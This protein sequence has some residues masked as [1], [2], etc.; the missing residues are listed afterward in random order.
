MS[1]TIGA[2]SSVVM[3]IAKLAEN[4]CHKS[5]TSLGLPLGPAWAFRGSPGPLLGR[6]WGPL[7]P[8]SL[9]HPRVPP[10][11]PLGNPWVPPGLPLDTPRAPPWVPAP[12]QMI[13]WPPFL[14]QMQEIAVT[15]GGRKATQEKRETFL[16]TPLRNTDAESKS[17]L[18]HRPWA[19]PAISW[20][21]IGFT[22]C[23][24]WAPRHPLDYPWAHPG[25]SWGSPGAPG[26]SPWSPLGR[27]WATPGHPCIPTGTPPGRPWA[28]L[29]CPSG[30]QRPPGG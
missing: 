24:S 30:P 21:V 11:P 16:G 6:P 19:S 22:R 17:A 13:C 25:P 26:D 23:F 5:C 20:N 14:A 3:L 15:C 28:P 18:L 2:A 8:P 27:P 10:L 12:P 1:A 29:C 9:G 4:I 7:A